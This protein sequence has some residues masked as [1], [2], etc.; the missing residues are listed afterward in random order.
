M[1]AT[2]IVLHLARADF[3]ERVR[4]Y[5]FLV[6]MGAAVFLGYQVL[7]GNVKMQAGHYGG[8]ANSAWLGAQMAVCASL[9]VSLV[10]FYIV[11]N[12]IER[13]R[14]TRVGQ[15]LASTPMSKPLYT[16]GKVLSNF[17]MFAAIVAV[18]VLS[19]V[20]MQL[21]RNEQF[22]LDLTQLLVPFLLI[23]LP[24]LAF[25][26]AIAVLFETLPG[27]RGGFGNVAWFFLWTALL[28]VPIESKTNWADISGISILHN[29]LRTEVSARF[30]DYKGGF[31]IGGSGEVF[32]QTFVWDGLHWTP[33]MIAQRLAWYGAAFLLAMVAAGFFDRFDPAR[34]WRFR[35]KEKLEASPP[36]IPGREVNG[37]TAGEALSAGSH[38]HLTPFAEV[39][40]RSRFAGV[41]IAE[42]KLMLKGQRW[43][44][45]AG[46]IGFWIASIASPLE[47]ARAIV[48]PLAWLWPVL[49][50]SAMGTREAKH[51]TGQ[52]IFSSARALTRQ[53]P[54]VWLAGVLLSACT[55][56]IVGL[57]LLLAGERGGLIAWVAGALFIPS[58]ALAL[59]VWGGTSKLFEGLFTVMWYIGPMNRV[60]DFDYCG[61]TR[62][63]IA[64]G[65]PSTYLGAS[66]L[67]LVAA[68]LGRYRQIRG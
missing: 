23:T 1:S 15:I 68:F 61:A 4:R 58:L 12:T 10:G 7:I 16:V 63:A 37:K 47:N 8:A 52:L 60:P 26:S 24:G 25:I 34:G 42:I 56:G 48:L 29:A 9:F 62:A 11:K 31:S 57:R 46:V 2:R 49:L 44:W 59:G 67:L 17:G 33:K 39:A 27:F 20:V 38:A 45:Y 43:I 18:L 55:G 51:E 36:E 30:P 64:A 41:L 6:T 35:R 66:V 14:Q 3:L 19:T 5:S 32:K 50:W 21:W 13:D 40:N 53:L 28:V 22:P 65:I 54:A